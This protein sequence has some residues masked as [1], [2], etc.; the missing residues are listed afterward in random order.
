MWLVDSHPVRLS[1]IVYTKTINF[2]F[3]ESTLQVHYN[4]QLF[5]FFYKKSLFILSFIR[6]TVKQSAT[7]M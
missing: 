5:K 6:N 4:N 1:E 3:K 2:Y 7:E